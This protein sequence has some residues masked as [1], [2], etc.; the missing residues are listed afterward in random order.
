MKRKRIARDYERDGE[1]YLFG[2]PSSRWTDMT[3]ER[4]NSRH[5]VS[6]VADAEVARLAARAIAILLS[7]RGVRAQ[8]EARLDCW[9]MRS[10]G[11]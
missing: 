2:V 3:A 1:T 6:G 7:E 5:R 10:V 9:A 4:T 8:D 11:T